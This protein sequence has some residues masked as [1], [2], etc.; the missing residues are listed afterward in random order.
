L[1]NLRR[2][3]KAK[4]HAASTLPHVKLVAVVMRSNLSQLADLVRLASEEGAESLSVQHLRHDFGESSLPE[5]YKPMRI[6]I[7]EQSLSLADPSRVKYYFN[8]ARAEAARLNI[9]LRLPNTALRTYAG[10]VPGRECC[11]WPWRG[12]Y[13]GYDGK[14]MPC[15]MV[16][17]PDRIHFG[18]MAEEGVKNLW[19]NHA[20][21][22][23]RTRLSSATP[24]DVCRSCADINGQPR[25]PVPI[26]KACR[27]SL[28]AGLVLA[29]PVLYFG[30]LPDPLAGP[31]GLPALRASSALPIADTSALSIEL[32]A[33][34]PPGTPVPPVTPAPAA[35]PV[36]VPGRDAALPALSASG[37]EVV[38]A[39][40]GMLAPGAVVVSPLREAAISTGVGWPSRGSVWPISP[41]LP[42]EFMSLLPLTAM[43]PGSRGWA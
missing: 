42:P 19:N 11:D 10:D 41:A 37:T 12:S 8:E 38:G 31:R 3:M 7:D 20:Y 34:I 16:A 4:A 18:S 15:C 39:G 14:A 32:D 17:T 22:A 30:A 23:F 27:R 29:S 13:I 43:P 40:R 6:F 33:V 21:C 28:N 5:Q 9:A 1:R 24:P 25:L 36:E 2:L 35:L 26:S